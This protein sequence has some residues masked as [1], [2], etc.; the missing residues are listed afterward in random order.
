M[1]LFD[2]LSAG[3]GG[4]GMGGGGGG[5]FLS[6][7]GSGFHDFMHG[8]TPEL[9]INER[10]DLI[11]QTANPLPMQGSAG[12]EFATRGVPNT[13]PIE[14]MPSMTPTGNTTGGLLS[15]LQDPDSRGLTFG[16]KLFAA[17]GALQGDSGG[18]ATFI[19]N[20]RANASAEDEKMRQRR[21]ALLGAKAFRRNVD[22]NGNMNFQGYATDLGDAFDPQKAAE[23]QKLLA[24][25]YQ[26]A[27]LANG[28]AGAFD[29]DTGS[30]TQQIAGERKAPDGYSYMPNGQLSPIDENYAAGQ[31]RIYGDRAQVANEYKR[32]APRGGGGGN[33]IGGWK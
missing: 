18:A 6:N 24:H 25:K 2:F 10:P 29:P 22:A 15:K 3:G 27:S 20:Q 33:S 14:Q 5:G 9:A 16:D 13:G 4:G 11:G 12:T 32:F 26:L 21:N 7:L 8:T 31:R 23:L 28:G 30:I 1:G 19:Q 17:G